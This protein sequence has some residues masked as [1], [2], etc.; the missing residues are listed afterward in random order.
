MDVS[1]QVQCFFLGYQFLEWRLDAHPYYCGIVWGEW[2]DLTVNGCTTTNFV[3]HIWYIHQVI[4]FVKYEG[5][6]LYAMATTLHSIIDCEPLKI[7]RV[8]ES[9]CFGHVMSKAH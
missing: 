8:H 6:D 7:I 9:T 4:A 5:T 3:G 1:W 2:N